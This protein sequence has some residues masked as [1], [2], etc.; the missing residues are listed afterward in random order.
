MIRLQPLQAGQMPAAGPSRDTLMDRTKLKAACTE[1]LDTLAATHKIGHESNHAN[2][3]VLRSA[4]G[5]SVEMMLEKGGTGNANLW[6]RSDFAPGISTDRIEQRAYPGRSVNTLTNNKGK[7][8]YGRH[9]GLRP[10][11]QLATADLT[12]F[13]LST[14][15]D[16]DQIISVLR[17][18]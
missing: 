17:A 16:L 11:E 6:V 7:K 15:A 18:A 9:S 13:T 1:R 3:Y 4:K 10:M 8:V 12:R 14:V 5:T 2:R